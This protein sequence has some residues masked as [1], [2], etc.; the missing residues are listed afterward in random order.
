MKVKVSNIITVV[1]NII[2]V[3]IF[4]TSYYD[5]VYVRNPTINLDYRRTFCY[6]IY[7][8]IVLCILAIVLLCVKRKTLFLMPFIVAMVFMYEILI[9]WI[10]D[11]LSLNI[12]VI[13]NLAWMLTFCVFYMYSKEEKITAN[14]SFFYI[15]YIGTIIYCVLII[16]NIRM[17]LMGMDL[18]GGIISSLYYSL[19]YLGLILLHSSS[20][21][22]I[23][24][25]VII[26]MMIL[27]S[28]KRA[29]LFC[30]VIGLACYAF[31]QA[32][33]EGNLKDRYKKYLQLFLLGVMALIL[34]QW[35]INKYNIGIIDRLNSLATDGGSGR[36]YIWRSVISYF[37]GSSILHK[38]FGY[39]FHAVPVLIRPW[40]RA[41]F[42]HNSFLEVLF[43]FG[44]V[45]LTFMILGILWITLN[46]YRMLKE[47]YHDTSVMAYAWI[48]MIL[49]S[50]FGYFFEESRFIMPVA[51]VCGL[52][53]GK[54]Q[55]VR[56]G[57]KYGN[58]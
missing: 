47:R 45:G 44:Y 56:K 22:K 55:M 5:T 1:V 50:L 21:N 12:L 39:G 25:S 9:S 20:K 52:C 58:R 28:T 13:E 14:K 16:P 35:A 53:M 37:E 8:L 51:V 38:L 11:M 23:I 6:I 4:I 32:Y 10:F 48:V 2:M 17:H 29:G 41:L 27:A 33:V 40:G 7:S 49:L 46:G 43:D 57:R 3:L 54:Y 31:M 30:F 34:A 19:G 18:R 42:A 24:F 36:D 26:G 15:I